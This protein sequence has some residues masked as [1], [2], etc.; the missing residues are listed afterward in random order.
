MAHSNT[1]DE[2]VSVRA[3]DAVH[4]FFAY[5]LPVEAYP[6]S[7]E[8]RPPYLS[9]LQEL[10]EALE[11]THSSHQPVAHEILLQMWKLHHAAASKQLSKNGAAWVP[12]FG[13]G[14]WPHKPAP[15]LW[16]K[17]E[18]ESFTPGEVPRPPIFNVFRL[19][20]QRKATASVPSLMAGRGAFM[21][22]G[23]QGNPDEFYSRCELYF[24]T[25]IT[26]PLHLAYP[27]FFPLLDFEGFASLSEE[28]ADR[29]LKPV[30]YYVRESIE[31]GGLLIL[32]RSQLHAVF[33]GLHWNVQEHRRI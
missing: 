17:E 7:E 33:E 23:V 20:G 25:F 30:Q 6:F 10:L 8:E 21:Q 22:I 27:F 4:D 2:R 19:K 24:R 18:F 32:S 26:E 5:L 9:I 31:D 16:T 1:F 11:R 3:L 12:M 14:V 28:V 15:A 29:L 13:V